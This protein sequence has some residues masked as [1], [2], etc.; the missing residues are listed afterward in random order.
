MLDLH[1]HLWPHEPGTRVPSYDELARWYES[2]SAA[3][4]DQ[5]AITEHSHRF[6][7]V[8]RVARQSWTPDGSPGL[9]AAAAHVWD[10]EGGAHLDDYVELLTDAQRRG[11]PLL[12]GLEVDHLPGANEAIAEVLA[13][14]PFDVL[15]GSVHRLG[16][17]LFD[18]YDSPVFAA[19]W[20]Q[21]AVDE[22][23][24]AYVD[25]VADL[26]RS[27]LVDVIAHVD[28]I[29]VAGHRP[30]DVAGFEDRLCAA[31]APAGV[32]VEVSSAGWRKPV[33]EP[34]PA[35]RLLQSLHDTG[36]PLTTASDAHRADEIGYRFD[37]LYAELARLGIGALATFE[38]R[39]RR[40]YRAG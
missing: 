18:A 25:A 6:E 27:G 40:T 34:Y 37:E 16:S 12:V 11:L 24:A 7:E 20:E 26:A 22:V 21:R 9:R 36:L 39:T 29:K 13:A 35:P 2:A 14:Y 30:A 19:E 3:G 1:T 5:V 31:I 33:N 10:V 8:A 23:W 28:V 4:V 17:W 32:A 15:L 38:R